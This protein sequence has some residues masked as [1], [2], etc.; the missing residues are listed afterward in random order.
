MYRSL[1]V[2][3]WSVCA[4]LAIVIGHGV[5]SGELT[6]ASKYRCSLSLA[7]RLLLLTRFP[8][9]EPRDEG[10]AA[11]KQRVVHAAWALAA[12]RREQLEQRGTDAFHGED[13][14]V[15]ERLSLQ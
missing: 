13:D 8:G 15:L 3:E 7:S 1:S 6:A 10:D 9:L 5:S 11:V 14:T 2:G 4:S 12:Q